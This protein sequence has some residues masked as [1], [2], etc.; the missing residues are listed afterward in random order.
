MARFEDYAV[1]RTGGLWS[2]D[3]T[4]DFRRPRDWIVWHFTPVEN[5]DGIAEEGCLLADSGVDPACSP[6][7]LQ[8]KQERLMKAVD[9]ESYVES[10][11]GDHVPLYIAA[12]SPMLFRVCRYGLPNYAR[13]A[14]PLVFLG[15][16]VA[17]IVDAGLT[18]CVSDRNA[19]SPLVEFTQDLTE[20]PLLL[21]EE[22]LRA[23]YWGDTPEDPGRRTR[24]AAEF[25][26]YDALPLDLLTVTVAHTRRTAQAVDEALSGYNYDGTFVEP[27][28]YY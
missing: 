20:V 22:V 15:F 25:L 17:K 24:R 26:V 21:D 13:G 8:M 12:K 23:Q 7:N 11:V 27:W 2:T 28:M 5:L 4:F 1:E 3:E 14:D 19:T 10:A 18:W 6:G 16:N 9:L